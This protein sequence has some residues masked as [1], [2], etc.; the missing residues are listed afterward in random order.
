MDG[1]FGLGD[2][3]VYGQYDIDEGIDIQRSTNL[4]VEVDLQ[5]KRTWRPNPMR[6][7]KGT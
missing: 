1:G 5:S 6:K 2:N 4:Q 3:Y 7:P